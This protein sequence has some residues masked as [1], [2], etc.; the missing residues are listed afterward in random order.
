MTL[1]RSAVLGIAAAGVSDCVSN[2]I[3]VLKTTRQT[4]ETT[5]SYREAA[6]RVLDQDGWAGLF[7]R[8]LSTRLA[9][10][11]IQAALFTV[12]WKLLEAQISQM[13]FFS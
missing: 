4:S 9:T 10:N 5:I 8:G 1:A 12:V 7:G 11:A 6:R 2:S 3:R 13:G